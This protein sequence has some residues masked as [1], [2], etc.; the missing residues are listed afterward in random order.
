MMSAFAQTAPE[1]VSRM[2]QEVTKQKE[3]GM[4]LMMD[5]KIPILGTFTTKASMLGNKVC[6]EAL[7]K[8]YRV[9]SW[10]DG[11]TTWVYDSRK[12]TV[13]IKKGEPVPSSAT[14]GKGKEAEMFTGITDGFDVSIS[15]ETADA[16]YI[17]CRKSRTNKEKD[18]P[19]TM[20]LVVAKKTFYP[21]SLS[22]KMAG[23]TLTMHDVVFGVSEKQ[24]TFDPADYPDATIED[25]R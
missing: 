18:D 2:E 22:A 6:I 12:G 14:T 16:W 4:A 19:K 21:L 17:L 1:I 9:V 20:D 23:V 24:V 13:E 11:E 15:K 10:G 7:M 5:F 3:N 8:E 25:K